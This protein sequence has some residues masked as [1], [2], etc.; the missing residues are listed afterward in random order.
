MLE[1]LQPLR[2]VLTISTVY[3]GMPFGSGVVGA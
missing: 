2:H 3:W 1:M